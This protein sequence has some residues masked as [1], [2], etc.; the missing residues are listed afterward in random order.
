MSVDKIDISVVERIAP[1]RGPTSS[2]DYNATIQEIINDLA[3]ISLSWNNDI[4]PLLDTLPCGST[5]IVREERTE[6]PN[7]YKNG[8]D[9]SQIFLDLT[10]TTLTDNGKYF[11]E[12]LDRPLTIKESLENVQGQLNDAIQELQVEIAKVNLNAGITSRQK[13]AIGSRIFDPETTSSPTSIDGITQTNIRSIDQI[14]LDI[15]GDR[16][17]LTGSGTQT[18]EYSIFEQLKSIQDGH[19]YNPIFN[20]LTHENLD[21]H[22]HRYHITPIGQLNGLNK[23]Y[24]LPGT[25]KF[26]Q[27]TLRVMLNG[28]EL[29]KSIDY[30][31]HPDLRGFSISPNHR[32]LENDGAGAD[33]SLWIHYDVEV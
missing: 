26:I 31:E 7:P 3:S 10:S 30:F 18:I 16:D 5:N 15:S 14:A 22:T 4:Q 6:Y 20:T 1:N 33:D 12:T 32:A 23:D 27:G 9:G 13:Q 2:A 11:D 17:Y 24:I 29:K 28:M 19:A 25:E 8:L 21:L